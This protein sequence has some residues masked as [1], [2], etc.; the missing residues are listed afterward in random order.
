LADAANLG[1]G[2]KRP[3]SADAFGLVFLAIASIA[4]RAPAQDLPADPLLRPVCDYPIA[5]IADCRR[6]RRF[7]SI[8]LRPRNNAPAQAI[9]Q[10][11]GLAPSPTLE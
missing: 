11:E 2:S 10:E 9:P 1:V 3:L 5:M 6:A 4:G 8:H 7:Y